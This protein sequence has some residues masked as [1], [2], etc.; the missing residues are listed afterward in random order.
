[1]E[2]EPIAHDAEARQ[3]ISVSPS[4]FQFVTWPNFVAVLSLVSVVFQFLAFYEKLNAN[5][6]TRSLYFLAPTVALVIT[7]VCDLSIARR[8]GDSDT[9][10]RSM[11]G[12]MLSF[13][14]VSVIIGFDDPDSVSPQFLVP[15]VV[16][17]FCSVLPILVFVVEKRVDVEMR[18]FFLKCVAWLLFVVL[19]V[20][21]LLAIV[22]ACI[23]SWILIDFPWFVY[24]DIGLLC[25]AHV[26]VIATVDDE[27]DSFYGRLLNLLGFV[28]ILT[29]DSETL[30]RRCGF[31]FSIVVDIVCW[32]FWNQPPVALGAIAKK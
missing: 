19:A 21:L 27:R 13:Q 6:S 2:S 30:H 12:K 17:S 24:A 20:K 1:M 8:Y 31:F 5:F 10:L 22:S 3:P 23:L 29:S 28:S 16:F 18:G 15:V 7:N 9:R 26:I 4:R 11:M 25:V 14:T 32:Y